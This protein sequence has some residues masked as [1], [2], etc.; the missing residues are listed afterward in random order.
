[1]DALRRIFLCLWGLI[2]IARAAVISIAVI[3]DPVATNIV[4]WVETIFGKGAYFWPLL[5]TAAVML[6]IGFL[7]L[8][9]AFH[10][11]HVEQRTRVVTSD[12]VEVNISV[13][14]IEHVVKRAVQQVEDISEA[15]TNIK[16]TNGA[17]AVYLYL[18]VPAETNIPETAER[19]NEEVRNMLEATT[20]LQVAELK[21]LVT[22][23]ANPR[24][25]TTV[26]KDKGGL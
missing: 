15:K 18:T 3:Q 23:V 20:G 7:S 25:K 22:A 24:T 11:Q 9:F 2:G 6:I 10:R 5:G 13:T 1:M 4:N 21:V 8:F 19:A 26:S 14:A 17:I 16:I 12:G